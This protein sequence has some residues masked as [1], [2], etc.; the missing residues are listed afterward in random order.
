M[1]VRVTTMRQNGSELAPARLIDTGIAPARWNIAVTAALVEGRAAGARDAIRFHRYEP[2]VLIGA[3][4]EAEK[5]ADL[6]ACRRH[7]VAV[8]RRVTGGGAVYMDEGVLAF[9]LVL[10]RPGARPEALFRAA[11]EAVSAALG[12]LGVAA[13]PDGPNGV[14]VEGAKICGL[15]GQFE[16][17]VMALQASVL[18]DVDRARLLEVLGLPRRTALPITTLADRLARP[19]A[20]A[21]VTSALAAALQA[22]FGLAAEPDRLTDAEAAA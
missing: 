16:G 18:V 5:A 3:G 14:A 10:K 12:R 15:A 19:V 1:P 21:Q 6:A 22:A 7:G 11:G 4:Q 13:A 17:P 20:M 9:D 8:A 2:S